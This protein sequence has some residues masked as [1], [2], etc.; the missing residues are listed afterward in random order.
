MLYSDVL[1]HVSLGND[2]IN[3]W[4]ISAALGDFP[5]ILFSFIY[6]LWS[7]HHMPNDQIRGIGL[8]CYWQPNLLKFDWR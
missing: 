5:Y 3:T 4:S 7:K 1:F 6:N 2:P 8:F